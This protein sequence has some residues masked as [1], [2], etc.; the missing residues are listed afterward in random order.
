LADWLQ[1]TCR[2]IHVSIV[3]TREKIQAQSFNLQMLLGLF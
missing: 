3:L 1:L 2:D